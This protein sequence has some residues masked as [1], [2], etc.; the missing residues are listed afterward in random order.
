MAGIMA[1]IAERSA[2]RLIVNPCGIYTSRHNVMDALSQCATVD[3]EWVA[4]Q[5]TLSPVPPIPAKVN[6]LL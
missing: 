4:L 1:R 3:T 2:V 5:V 6:A